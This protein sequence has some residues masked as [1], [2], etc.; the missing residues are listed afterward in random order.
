[1]E[2][3]SSD[4]SGELIESPIISENSYN[5]LSSCDSESVIEWNEFSFLS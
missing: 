1:M 2:K 5:N 3:S 4:L